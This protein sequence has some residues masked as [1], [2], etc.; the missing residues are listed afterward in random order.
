[1]ILEKNL[2]FEIEDS[3]LIF[4]KFCVYKLKGMIYDY[5]TKFIKFNPYYQF[6][7][8][9]RKIGA[10]PAGIMYNYRNTEYSTA[11]LISLIHKCTMSKHGF[12]YK[13]IGKSMLDWDA[14]D[15]NDVNKTVMKLCKEIERLCL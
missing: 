4:S 12:P 1:M 11:T 3:V 8:R 7:Y 9:N 13:L 2:G 6:Y 10:I 15:T 5:K 14:M